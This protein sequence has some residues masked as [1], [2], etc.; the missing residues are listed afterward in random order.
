MAGAHPSRLPRPGQNA[1]A[2]ETPVFSTF[3]GLS[4]RA[5]PP[6]WL[7]GCRG[8]VAGKVAGA[9]HLPSATR[10][11]P[12]FCL[13]GDWVRSRSLLRAFRSTPAVW[14]ASGS[15]CLGTTKGVC[16]SELN[17]AVALP[18]RRGAPRPSIPTG[19]RNPRRETT[20]ESGEPYGATMR[21]RRPAQ[22]VRRGR[23]SRWAIRD[24]A[25]RSGP[26]QPCPGPREVS[27]MTSFAP[28]SPQRCRVA[29]YMRRAALA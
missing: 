11:M 29:V 7:W 2:D 3:R 21:V 14:A 28:G 4:N 20:D 22:P 9:P 17:S 24:G 6:Q 16:N 27:Q 19:E 23:C 1:T 18:A 5:R 8:S 25:H 12:G 15:Q 26:E 13:R 10:R